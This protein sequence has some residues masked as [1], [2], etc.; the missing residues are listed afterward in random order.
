MA[1]CATTATA[2]TPAPV[3]GGDVFAARTGELE[4]A[5]AQHSRE[6]REVTFTAGEQQW[7]WDDPIVG[8]SWGNFMAWQQGR[9]W[10]VENVRM[11]QHGRRGHAWVWVP[12]S[13]RLPSAQ[14]QP[15]PGDRWSWSS[16]WMNGRWQWSNHFVC[17]VWI[18]TWKG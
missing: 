5:A 13:P 7:L 12:D 15:I 17:W 11:M 16:G 4:E 14:L 8:G 3:N 9:W 1:S 10:F 2:S 18:P 6:H